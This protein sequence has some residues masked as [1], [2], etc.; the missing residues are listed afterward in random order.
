[1]KIPNFK[2]PQRSL[3]F[4]FTLGVLIMIVP[5]IGMLY[6][7][8]FYSIQVVREQVSDSYKN[9]LSLYMNQIDS[10]LNDVDAYLNTLAGAGTGYSLVALELAEN[11]TEY[12]MAKSNLYNQLNKDRNLYELIDS[13]FVY[14]KHREDYMDLYSVG[15][16]YEERELLKE[17]VSDIIKKGDVPTGLKT[18]RW[19]HA[20]VGKYQ[21]LI[22]IAVRGNMYIGGWI[23]IDELLKPLEALQLG[24]GGAV[25]IADNQ[26]LPLTSTQ[27][28]YDQGISLQGSPND[29]YISGE[30]QHYL[31]VGMESYRGNFQLVALIPERSILSNLPYLKK[32]IWFITIAMMIFILLGFYHI[33]KVLL[34]PIKRI[35]L[36]MSRVRVG[37]WGVRVKLEKDTEEFRILGHSFNTMMEEMQTLR[38]NVLEEQIRKQREELQRLQLQVNPHFFLNSLNIVY[39][40]AKV[41][42]H[43]LI[44]EMSDSLI[45]YFRFLF[46]SN[47]SFVKLHE[48]L[49]HTRNYMHIQNLRFPEQLVWKLEAPDYLGDIPVPPLVIQSFVENSIKHAITMEEPLLIHLSVGFAE[50][51]DGSKIRIKIQDTGKGFAEP[52]LRELQAGNSVENKQGEH[53]GIW[54]VQRRL[55]LLY[56]EEVSI[57]FDN[58]RVTGG[59]IVELVIP[60]HPEKERVQ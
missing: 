23:R 13:F 54:N 40:L 9:T 34:V 49:E 5:L 16:T 37:D 58:D 55:R 45:D 3:R 11:D 15:V 44:M 1:M 46:R 4:Q 19:R 22:N 24:D 27:L 59:A 33:R 30:A 53:T 25:L 12:Y 31:T 51:S 10:H 60:T 8:H 50:G 6:Y 52:I 47:T 2:R 21:Y 17:Y 39:N 18:K 36:V 7:Y 42:N 38:V 29:Y 48:E 26:G 20:Q 43:H 35:L 41:K 14:A 28:V 56:K 57:Q 32:V